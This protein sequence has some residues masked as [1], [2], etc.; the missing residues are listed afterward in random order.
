MF[1]L[2]DDLT[3]AHTPVGDG[4]LTTDGHCSYS[5]DRK[6]VLN[7]TYPQGKKR[8][9]TLMLYRPADNKRVDIGPSD[10]FAGGYPK[11]AGHFWRVKSYTTN[12]SAL[13]T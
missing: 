1:Y 8:L 3:G 5:P 10:E 13:P 7:D 2:I 11:P 12:G 6:W 9:Q 4:V